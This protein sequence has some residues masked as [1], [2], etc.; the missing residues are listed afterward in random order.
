MTRGR[1]P[2]SPSPVLFNSYIFAAFFAIVFAAY[3]PLR[4][5]WR[6]QNALLL[7][8]SYVFYGWWDI[9]FL[10][11]IVL[12]TC[13]DYYCALMIGR[14]E[15]SPASRAKASLGLLAAA[16]AFVTVQ[17]EA[18]TLARDQL[19]LSLHVD[20]GSLL[21]GTFDLGWGVLVAV[22]AL[23]LVA[24]VAHP[25]LAALPEARRRKMFVALSAIVN[26]SVLGFF[27]YFDFFAA[28]FSEAVSGTFG[29]AVS[30][31]TLD[32]I[33]PVGISFYTFQS[34]SYTIDV[35]RRDVEPTDKLSTVATYLAFFPQ[36]VA[37]PIE[38]ASHLLPQFQRPRERI[39]GDWHTA[40]WLIGW[41]LF[42]KIVIADNLAETVNTVFGPYDGANPS[43]MVPDDGLRLLV[44]VY[45]FALQ[46]YGDFSGYT[47]MARGLG[48]LLGFDLMLNFRLPYFA[49]SPS[50]FWKR[51]HIS[52]SSW[53]RDYL[54]IPLGGNRG[55]TGMMYRNLMVTMILGG[56]WHGAAWNFVLWGVYHGGI[57]VIYRA[58]LPGVDNLRK[59]KK[60]L[61]SQ[62]AGY[63]P[64][65]P[66]AGKDLRGAFN[67]GGTVAG[68]AIA[69]HLRRAGILFVAGLV[70]F[71][72]T[73][74]GWLLFRAQNMTAIAVFTESIFLHPFGSEAA[75]AAMQDVL[76]YGSFLL[77]YQLA[78]VLSGTLDPLAR[79]GFFV[80]VTAWTI[81]VMGLLAFAS[82]KQQAF[83][84]FAF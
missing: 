3:W 82:H 24:N 62:A 78:Q 44:G 1:N 4:R 35:Y 58:F 21:P 23:V 70:M 39:F 57:Q 76:F 75:W 29:I 45:A 56:L 27:K 20:W 26:L 47:D 51:W 69:H 74:Y 33:L 43:G 52:L 19:R 37:G 63:V 22:A 5:Y 80:R 77:V 71:H 72:L 12:T 55:G 11:L 6:A 2:P 54:Y 14:G 36:L 49:I 18:L 30:D 42:K 8:A 17:W 7:I 38:R 40:L 61:P 10:C 73:C 81:L 50:D 15:A 84:Y 41:G 83:I 66:G 65:K 79:A 48:R 46:I 25:W 16:F 32:V 67:G 59:S 9:R 28:S 64:T 31:W 68:P 60:G 53:L 34:M 13:T